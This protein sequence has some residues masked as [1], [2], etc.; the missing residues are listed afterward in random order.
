MDLSFY[1]PAQLQTLKDAVIA[2]RLRRVTGGTVSSGSKNG[3]SFSM[4][5]LSDEA[6][7]NLESELSRKLKTRGPSKRRISFTSGGEHY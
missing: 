4:Q 7:S 2:E 3:K 6:L 1:T 5:L